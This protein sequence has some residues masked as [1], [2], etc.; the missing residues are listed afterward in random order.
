VSS[1]KK[2]KRRRRALARKDARGRVHLV[3]HRDASGNE[4]VA[5]T[6]AVFQ[7]GWQ[8]E[9][10]T[11]TANTARALLR[12]EPTLENTREL[13]RH[14]MSATSRLAEG[15]L[16]QAPAGAV[17]CHAGCDHCCYQVVG[18]TPPEAFAIMDHLRRT[19]SPA[20]LAELAARAATLHAR[21]HGLSSNERFSPDYPCLFLDVGVGKCTI[22]EARPLAC[23]G[24]NSL[25]AGECAERLRDPVARAAF[26]A[27]GSGGKSYMEPIR[28]M[29]AISAGLQLTLAELY[30]LDMRPLELAAALY[31]LL[32]GDANALQTAW[33]EGESPLEAA[34]T[35]DASDDAGMR[36]ASGA[37]AL[38]R[39]DDG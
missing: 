36:V 12:D 8:N 23:R 14:A 1:R 13:A 17:A 22:Y 34:R 4:L 30:E 5:L 29:H 24:M 37:L 3:L 35:T 31:L 11:G 10:T 21:A 2:D 32:N 19:R 15:L 28:A 26:I 20:E 25:D 39:E 27:Q 7:E 33:L 18:V 38:A 16:A 6:R 9:L